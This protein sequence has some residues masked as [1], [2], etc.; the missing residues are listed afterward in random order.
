MARMRKETRAEM[1][2]RNHRADR[3]W[4]AREKRIEEGTEFYP[5]E[6]F[7]FKFTIAVVAVVFSPIIFAMILLER[8]GKVNHRAES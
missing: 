6:T 3:A 2:A 5:P 7:I 4:L 1:I 8:Y